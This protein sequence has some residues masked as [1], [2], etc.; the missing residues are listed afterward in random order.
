MEERTSSL[1]SVLAPCLA[2]VEFVSILS[3]NSKWVWSGN[4]TITNRRQ[5]CDTAVRFLHPHIFAYLWP[6]M[7]ESTR[8]GTKGNPKLEGYSLDGKWK[9][10]C[11]QVSMLTEISGFSI[12]C[13]KHFAQVRSSPA[14]FC[15]SLWWEIKINK[16]YTQ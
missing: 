11:T 14:H 10:V 13:F 6:F 12:R 3:R 9:K 2:Q 7:L 1:L 8:D 16:F 5:P 15:S 4:T